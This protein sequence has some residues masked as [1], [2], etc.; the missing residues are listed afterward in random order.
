MRSFREES[1]RSP[2]PS[3]PRSFVPKKGV[4]KI[5]G[6]VKTDTG[7]LRVKEFEL[8]RSVYCGLCNHIKKRSFFLTFSLSYDFVL[9]A[10][11]SVAFTGRENIK[12]I[13]KRCLAHPFRKRPMLIGGDDLQKV[14]DASICLI[15]YK[16]L[17]D[18]NDRDGGFFRRLRSRIAL[19]F[20]SRARKKVIDSGLSEL[21]SIIK[22]KI[23]LLSSKEREK[24]DSVYDCA[25]IFGEL[26]AEVFSKNIAD[27]RNRRCM[28]LLGYRVG[29][30][31][32]IADALDD[33]EKDRKDGAYN[34]FVLSGVDTDSES[35]KTDIDMALR[36]ELSE[37]EKALDLMDITDPGIFNIIENIFYLGMPSVIQKTLYKQ[38]KI[39]KSE[40]NQDK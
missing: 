13:K 20:A 35:F 28:H 34:P 1:D 3:F 7:E 14:A 11:F 8:Y 16:L 23:S 30:W 9:P 15:Y 33:I 27:G 4:I 21:D 37:C 6:Y 32:Y 18:K 17:D 12:I 2:V 24:S 29:R 22:E 31:I 19:P 26:L 5:F 39:Q 40:R 38:E 36:L 25:E 10:L